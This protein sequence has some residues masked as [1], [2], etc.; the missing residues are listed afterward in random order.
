[1]DRMPETAGETWADSEQKVK[2]IF[3]QK[4]KIQREIEV[5]RAHRT[6]KLDKN[7]DRPRSVIVKFLRFKDKTAVLNE[8]RNLKST[9]IFINE[10]YTDAVRLKRKELMPKLKAA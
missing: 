4:L 2:E 7:R 6:G 9:N 1:M 3:K 8:A 10:D 5:E